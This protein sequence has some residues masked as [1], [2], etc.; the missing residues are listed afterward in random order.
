[1][2][3]EPVFI[4][5][6]LLAHLAVP[7]KLLEALRLRAAVGYWLHNTSD[8]VSRAALPS[9]YWRLPSGQTCSSA[10]LPTSCSTGRTPRAVCCASC[11]RHARS[12]DTI[13]HKRF[14]IP[15][16]MIDDRLRRTDGVAW[17]HKASTNQA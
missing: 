7:S 14:A 12:G 5:A 6:L 15:F 11:A 4:A 8:T 10:L 2:A 3:F 13:V 16:P 17:G 9:I 1:M